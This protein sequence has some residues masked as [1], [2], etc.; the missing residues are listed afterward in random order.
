MRS[1]STGLMKKAVSSRNLTGRSDSNRRFA[2]GDFDKWVSGLLRRFRFS[3][4]L[5]LCCGTGNQLVLFAALPGV[6]E[7]YGIDRSKDSLYIARQRL[8]KI[9]GSARVIL[10]AA[11]ME[12]LFRT[13]LF[14]DSRFDLISCFYGLYYSKDPVKTLTDMVGHLGDNGS[15]MIVGP[16]GKN[17]SALFRLLKRHFELP[18]LVLR[19]SETFMEKEVYPAL[20]GSCE[21][22]EDS[23]VNRVS[24]PDVASLI[25]YWRSSTFYF[26][27]HEAAVRRDIEKHFKDDKEF[28]IEKHVKAYIGRKII[29]EHKSAGAQEHRKDL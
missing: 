8:D 28:I 14:E 26:P 18:E 4:V 13:H 12:G 24:Y 2:K 21:V 20:K 11:D 5:D 23:F 10:K 16:Y 9:E 19:S 27:E 1:D 3:N 7:I 15:V 25:K 17:N 29:N 22:T 6:S